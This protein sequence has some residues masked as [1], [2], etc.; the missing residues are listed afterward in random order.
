MPF[1]P[2]QRVV[3][4]TGKGGV[5][6]STVAAALARAEADRGGEVVLVEFEGSTAAAR[7]LG[8][9]S[10]GVRHLVIEYFDALVDVMA[11][12]LGSRILSRM[13]VNHRA[14]RRLVRAVPALR[15]LS[16]LDRVRTLVETRPS[17]RAVVDLP[18]SG[19]S[20]DWLRVPIAAQRFLRAGPAA[21]I[22]AALRE[23]V[24]ASTHSAIVVVSTVEPVVASETRELCDRI[25]EELQRSPSLLVANRVPHAPTAEQFDRLRQAARENGAWS[26]LCMAA[27]EDR[28]LA[29][30]TAQALRELETV[31]GAP[32]ATV[33]EMHVDPSPRDVLAHLGEA[34]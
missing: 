16:I 11:S 10:D 34:L 26:D 5:G 20:V 1:S 4:V 24:L 9:D 23:Q 17:V 13:L 28:K 3:F 19:H 29:R 31:A 21:E 12:V 33:P 27:G 30:E 22:C 14:V 8:D 2:Q 32:L 7:A 15:E 18:A 6:K 25:A